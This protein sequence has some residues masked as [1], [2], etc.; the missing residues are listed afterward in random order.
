M[1]KN[2]FLNLQSGKTYKYEELKELW[3]KTKNKPNDFNY[4]FLSSIFA[5]DNDQKTYSGSIFNE[6]AKLDNTEGISFT[7]IDKLSSKGKFDEANPKVKTISSCNYKDIYENVSKTEDKTEQS[8]EKSNIGQEK[9]SLAELAKKEKI[10]PFYVTMD[11]NKYIQ[12]E[13][14]KKI[15]QEKVQNSKE[16]I[17]KYAAEHPEDTKIQDYAKI[18]KDKSLNFSFENYN[19]TAIA[20][21]K[22]DEN[23]KNNIILYYD[24]PNYYD[25]KEKTTA[26]LLHELEHARSG[27]N[28]SSIAEETSAQSYA[29]GTTRKMYNIENV[30]KDDKKYLEEFPKR[31]SLLE[32]SPGY[33]G[34]PESLGVCVEGK[35]QSIEKTK[36]SYIIKSIKDN[37]EIEVVVNLDKKGAPKT[38]KMNYFDKNNNGALEM[39]FD[40]SEYN[41]KTKTFKIQANMTE[42]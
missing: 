24:A 15:V 9:T 2:L 19:P 41:K 25:T 37:E 28:L 16:D 38:G 42:E 23:G 21:N 5:M 6:I 14:A 7:D 17:I 4:G 30:F 22:L 31:Y 29:M 3:D 33:N 1:A 39:S 10:N 18:L 26:I 34:L 11:G 8:T 12:E 27:D 32:N 36:D 40:L 35:I 13:E 20:E